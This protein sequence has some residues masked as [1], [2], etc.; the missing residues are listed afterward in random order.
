MP[1]WVAW[2]HPDH[3]THFSK[4]LL[5]LSVHVASR[6][7]PG[8]ISEKLQG[9]CPHLQSLQV[10]SSNISKKAQ[11]GWEKSV[12]EPAVAGCLCPSY[13]KVNS[14]QDKEDGKIEINNLVFKSSFID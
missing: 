2:S 11:A 14:R 1:M 8:G 4:W 5:R 13:M 6:I 3:D 9:Q 10:L 7:L 12:T